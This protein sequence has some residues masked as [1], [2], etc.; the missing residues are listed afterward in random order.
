MKAYINMEKFLKVGDI[1]VKKQKFYQH[2][3]PISIKIKILI[4]QCYLISSLL[5]EQVFNILLA[6]KM[7]EN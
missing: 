4:K 3:G 1:A 7:L 5:L 2:Q 6:T